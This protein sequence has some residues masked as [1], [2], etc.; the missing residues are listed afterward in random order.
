MGT[1]GDADQGEAEW[2]GGGCQHSNTINTINTTNQLIPTL[3]HR[4]HVGAYASD[5]VGGQNSCISWLI[6]E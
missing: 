2:K 1:L 5:H 3:S 4:I 6:V